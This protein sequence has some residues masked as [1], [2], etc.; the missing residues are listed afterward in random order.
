LWSMLEGVAGA[1][2]A[3]VDV[4]FTPAVDLNIKKGTGAGA[5]YFDRKCLFFLL[6]Y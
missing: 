5:V 3:L 2:R 6:E 4:P 1:G